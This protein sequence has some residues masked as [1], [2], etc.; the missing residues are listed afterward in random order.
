MKGVSQ[1]KKK[2]IGES[3][4]RSSQSVLSKCLYK[5]AKVQ[6][7]NHCFEVELN[8]RKVKVSR[9]IELPNCTARECEWES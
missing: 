4:S 9:P 3:T 8:L 2:G 5:G 7:E 6:V 1:D